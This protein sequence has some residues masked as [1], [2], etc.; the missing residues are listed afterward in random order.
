MCINNKLIG[1]PGGVVQASCRQPKAQDHCRDDEWKCW[2]CETC[3]ARRVHQGNCR[4]V[5]LRYL[6]G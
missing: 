4:V 5:Q 1:R 6:V 3:R 2:A